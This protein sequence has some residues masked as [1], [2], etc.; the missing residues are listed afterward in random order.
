[1][2]LLLLSFLLIFGLLYH[3]VKMLEMLFAVEEEKDLVCLKQKQLKKITF[4]LLFSPVLAK[5]YFLK[6]ICWASKTAVNSHTLTVGHVTLTR[7]NA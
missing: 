4:W 3:V 1:M 6:E 5:E 2:F 7:L